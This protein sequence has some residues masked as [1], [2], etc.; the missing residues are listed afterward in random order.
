MKTTAD[1]LITIHNSML[2]AFTFKDNCFTW[3]CRPAASGMPHRWLMT[4]QRNAIDPFDPIYFHLWCKKIWYFHFITTATI[5]LPTFQLQVEIPSMWPCWGRAR[6]DPTF[7]RTSPHHLAAVC[8]IAPSLCQERIATGVL[9]I[10]IPQAGKKSV[11]NKGIGP[12][13]VRCWPA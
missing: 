10:G 12:L 6:V 3:M 9:E 4:P 11:K 13:S 1:F 8:S 7:T 2:P 5:Q